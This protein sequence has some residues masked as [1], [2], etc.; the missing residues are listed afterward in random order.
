MNHGSQGMAYFQQSP[1]SGPMTLAKQIN[2][3]VKII[4]LF[5]FGQLSDQGRPP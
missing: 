1:T 2:L 3:I 5:N 4:K